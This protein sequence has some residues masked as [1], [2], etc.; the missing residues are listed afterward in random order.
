MNNFKGSHHKKTIIPETTSQLVQ[1]AGITEIQPR[2]RGERRMQIPDWMIE[3]LRNN[4][5]IIAFLNP[6]DHNDKNISAIKNKVIDAVGNASQVYIYL[7]FKSAENIKE[8]RVVFARP[9]DTELKPK[10]SKP[11]K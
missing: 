3:S 10:L 6:Q 7:E 5:N 2:K 4:E 1:S 8:N 11:P 9:K